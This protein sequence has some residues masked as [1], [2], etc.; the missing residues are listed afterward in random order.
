VRELLAPIRSGSTSTCGGCASTSSAASTRGPGGWSSS[1]TARMF[2][3][4]SPRSSRSS[5][6]RCGDQEPC[7][8]PFPSRHSS[9][10]AIVPRLRRATSTTVGSYARSE[11]P[12]CGRLSSSSFA[13]VNA[14]LKQ[15]DSP[16]R[17]REA[18]AVACR[19][20]GFI[21]K[22]GGL[23]RSRPSE[24]FKAP[25]IDAARTAGRFSSC[26]GRPLAR[27]RQRLLPVPVRL[28]SRAGC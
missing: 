27:N 21:A 7:R 11:W 19:V 9:F 15:V 24:I 23:F 10:A 12:L 18:Q 20:C 8:V 13:S 1:P 28:R 6:T 2:G 22:R 3:N 25:R 5:F 4:A 17:A 26:R 14:R 16:G